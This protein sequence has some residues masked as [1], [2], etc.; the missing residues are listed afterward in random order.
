[1]KT[2]YKVPRSGKKSKW[3]HILDLMPKPTEFEGLV[4]K[5]RIILSIKQ[6]IYKNPKGQN[7]NVCRSNTKG[8]SNQVYASFVKG[9]AIT[10]QPPKVVGNSDLLDLKVF[11]GHGREKIKDSLNYLHWPYDRYEFDKDDYTDRQKLIILRNAGNDDN[12]DNMPFEK[13]SKMDYIMQLVDFIQTDDWDRNKCKEWFK[14]RRT[15]IT[16]KTKAE[17]ISEAIKRVKAVGRVEHLDKTEAD[18]IFEE[19]FPNNSDCI[20]LIN[21]TDAEKD[22]QDRILRKLPHA[23]R[24]FIATGQPKQY[25]AWNGNAE[26]HEELDSSVEHMQKQFGIYLKLILRFAAKYNT[27]V[28]DGKLRFGEVPFQITKNIYQKIEENQDIPLKSI[29]DLDIVEDVDMTEE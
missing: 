4:W 12:G 26:S 10:E 9:I 7:I 6:P 23:I 25:C 19:A 22:N 24:H 15:T 16:D 5:E 29:I 2:Y 28:S 20:E 11:A 1:M 18:Q 27:L 13:M 14:T 17:Y 3:Q 8:R 21:A